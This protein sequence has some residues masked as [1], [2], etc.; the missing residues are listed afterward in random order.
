MPIGYRITKTCNAFN[1]L[2]KR[3]IQDKRTAMKQAKEHK[4][5]EENSK[6]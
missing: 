1:T 6:Y 3:I 5:F 4:V 2:T